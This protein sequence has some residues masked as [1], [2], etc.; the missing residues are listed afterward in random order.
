[1]NCKYILSRYKINEAESLKIINKFNSDKKS[2][3]KYIFV[4]KIL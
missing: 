2:Q 3:F 1:M 4:Y